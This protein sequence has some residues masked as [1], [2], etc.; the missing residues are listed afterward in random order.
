MPHTPSISDWARFRKRPDNRND[1]AV[2]PHPSLDPKTMFLD[3][4]TDP[5]EAFLE[6]ILDQDESMCSL[7][8][9]K[10]ALSHTR[11]TEYPNA[12]PTVLGVA[13]PEPPVS[14]LARPTQVEML[15]VKSR[16][17][18]QPMNEYP[19]ELDIKDGMSQD[20]CR[21]EEIRDDES[22]AGTEA[23]YDS[24]SM[25]S[26]ISEAGMSCARS[27]AMSFGDMPE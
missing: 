22:A 19:E 8:G 26:G 4:R 14:F 18:R 5:P 27:D 23:N 20:E 12:F 1:N 7:N 15:S 13:D 3:G 6:H 21:F 17:T 25:R 11:V 24:A 2:N 9:L 16:S 10:G